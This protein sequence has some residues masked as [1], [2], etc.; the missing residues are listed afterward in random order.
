MGLASQE[1]FPDLHVVVA[2]LSAGPVAP[3]D[4]IGDGDPTLVLRTCTSNGT[5]LKPDRKSVGCHMC[6]QNLTTL[7]T[8]RIAGGWK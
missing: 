4:G 2:A 5:L 3:G 8:L 7:L 1:A 6:H